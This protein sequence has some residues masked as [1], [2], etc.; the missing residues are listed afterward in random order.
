LWYFAR[1]VFMRRAALPVS[2]AFGITA[3]VTG[4]QPPIKTT[5]TGV[6]IDVAVLD[7][8]GEPVL[9]LA[10]QDFELSEDGN[11]QRI[12]SVTL[13]QGGV[14]K[15]SISTAPAGVETGSQLAAPAAEAA[16]PL[17]ATLPS[18]TA[19]LFDRLS[20]ESRALAR[21]AALAYVSTLAPAHDYA[22]VFLADLSLRTFQP[23]TNQRDSLARA[24]DVVSTTPPA[25][26]A[27]SA[28]AESK[29]VY[30]MDPNLSPT[31]GA[32]SAGGG[33]A[34]VADR[35]RK[36]KELDP[37]EARFIQMELRMREGY[38]RFLAEFDGQASLAG[39]RA[40]ISSFAAVPGR[41]SILY[42]TEKLP[43]TD[44]MKTKFDSLIGEANRANITVYPVDAVGLRVHSTGEDLRRNVAVA[45]ARGLGDE[46][47]D[48]KNAWTKELEA[49]DEM[50][51]SRQGVVL[52]RLA[53]ET[54]GFVVENTNDLAAGVARMQA[55]RTVYYLLAFQ[56]TNAKLDGKFRKVSV[57]VKRPKVTVR[58]RPG[59]V[60]T[61]IEIG[62]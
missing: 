15:A 38:Q 49:Q 20:P 12:L 7:G 35:Q 58:A 5:T 34:D 6:L 37:A 21:R 9:D 62:K 19:I 30:G 17:P 44:R 26:S 56:P 10:A 29:R 33:F 48:D 41:K 59:Y 47:R 52:G 39:L 53:K 2:L 50:L 28:E 32:E 8:K 31:A 23:F 42:F 45:G 25:N 16:A 61:S 60:A 57:K 27:A 51:N 3:L 18:V 4:Q 43:I 24:I 13:V 55:E 1:E 22:G 40:V 46:P 54:G 11:R 14:V 36:L